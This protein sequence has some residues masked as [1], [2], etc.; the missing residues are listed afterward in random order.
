MPLTRSIRSASTQ[1][2]DVAW[3]SNRL[4]GSHSSR[5]VPNRRRRAAGSPPSIGPIGALGNPH[6][7]S[8]NCSMVTAPIPPAASSGTHPAAGS[9]SSSP[10]S[11]RRCQTADATNGL[12]AEKMQ[13]RVSGPASPRV[14]NVSNFPSLATAS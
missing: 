8:S 4:P 11:A 14:A 7:W 6:V 9:A 3:Y 10:P 5:Q 12:V 13:K 2:A 1:C